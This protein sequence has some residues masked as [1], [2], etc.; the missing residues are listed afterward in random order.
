[1]RGSFLLKS[2]L[3]CSKL[4]CSGNS[5]RFD[6][7]FDGVVGSCIQFDC[8]NSRAERRALS[9]S[10]GKHVLFSVSKPH[11]QRL[12]TKPSSRTRM[13]STNHSSA[14]T[15]LDTW[16]TVGYPKDQLMQSS[17][18]V[19]FHDSLLQSSPDTNRD[20]FTREWDKHSSSH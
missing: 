6:S 2:R 7:F 4:L 17:N 18:V 19:N 5:A 11:T 16:L 12:S 3:S 10:T 14:R 9:I 15:L 1:M 8:C 20:F 13:I